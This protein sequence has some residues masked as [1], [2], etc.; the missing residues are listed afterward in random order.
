MSK[1]KIAAQCAHGALLAQEPNP[2]E[3][4]EMWF[5]TDMTKIILKASS[6]DLQRAIDEEN[7]TEVV[8]KGY[9]EVPPNSRTVVVLPVMEK[10]KAPSWT[11]KLPLL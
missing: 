4:Y 9:T 7:A 2:H 6:E 5:H 8:D 3:D 1:G 11:R 10:E